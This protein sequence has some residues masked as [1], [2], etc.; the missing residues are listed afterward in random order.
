MHICSRY[1]APHECCEPYSLLDRWQS[2]VEELIL[3]LNILEPRK[4]I[5]HGADLTQVPELQRRLAGRVLE[6]IPKNRLTEYWVPVEMTRVH[7]DQYC[8]L[9]VR[10]YP[11]LSRNHRDHQIQEVVTKLRQVHCDPK[12][13][14]L[15]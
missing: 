13:V 14:I 7:L 5:S 8:N 6:Y 11:T 1:R 12:Q 9:L 3:F 15:L 2:N 4:S 10:H